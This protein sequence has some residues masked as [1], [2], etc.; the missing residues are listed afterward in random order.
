MRHTFFSAVL[1]AILFFRL[2][3]AEQPPAQPLDAQ[4]QTY[5]SFLKENPQSIPA[6]NKLAYLYTRKVRQT[7]DFSYNVLAEKLVQRVLLL[8]PNNYDALL[9]ESIIHMAQHRFADA[10][11]S[12][13]KAIAANDYGSGAYGI[14]GDADY[15]LGS[16]Q[17]S[18]EAYDK[19][20]DLGPGAPYYARIA[21]YRMLAG[22]ASGAISAMRDALEAGDPRDSEDYAWYLLQLGILSFDSGKTEDAEA[23]FRQALTRHPASYNAWAGLAKVQAA[24]G[25]TKDAIASYQKALAI[26][27]MPDFSA[28]LGD[29]YA[30]SGRKQEAEKQYALVEYIGLISKINKEI[31]NRQ[32]AMFYADHDRKLQEALKLVQDEIIVRKDIYGYDALAWCLYKNGRTSES[33]KAIR[34]A[35][36]MGTRDARIFYHAGMIYS[37]AGARGRSME[38][39]RKALE[40]QPRFHPLYASQATEMIHRMENS[41]RSGL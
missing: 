31:Y 11:D 14:L 18:A 3:G 34:Q 30:L 29:L 27:P 4:I 28:A 21:S 6:L 19:M 2:A 9:N 10:R 35:L 16:Y 5:Q 24:Q 22:D 36:R 15:E 20:G 7:V 23:Y 40:T 39:L 17:E 37:A 32:I 26:V 33:V 38:F 13:R 41:S 8:E 1:L 25:R 12:A